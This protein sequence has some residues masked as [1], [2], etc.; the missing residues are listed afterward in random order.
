MYLHPTAGWLASWR[1]CSAGKIW[2]L[3]IGYWSLVAGH[4]L[5][6]AG[7]WSLAPGLNSKPQNRRI[8]NR[9]ISKDGIARAAQALPPRQRLRGVCAACRF[10][11]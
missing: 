7:H 6:A 3:V 1:S 10:V 2:L 11:F 9:R 4:W 8:S 5:L